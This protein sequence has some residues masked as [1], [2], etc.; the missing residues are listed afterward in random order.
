MVAAYAIG[1]YEP[2]DNKGADFPASEQHNSFPFGNN[3]S[4]PR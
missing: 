3:L 1:L 4:A 2:A